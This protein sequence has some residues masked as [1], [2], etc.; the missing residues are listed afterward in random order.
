MGNGL[1]AGCGWRGC[2]KRQKP[3]RSRQAILGQREAVTEG[4]QRLSLSGWFEWRQF[5][6]AF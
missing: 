5:Q 4:R 1:C 6:N 2:W 3:P